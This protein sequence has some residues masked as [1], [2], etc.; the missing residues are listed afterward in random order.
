MCIIRHW[1]DI[2]YSWA[3][4]TTWLIVSWYVVTNVNDFIRF[5]VHGF[6]LTLLRQV[7]KLTSSSNYATICLELYRTLQD[8]NFIRNIIAN[9]LSW[10]INSL[11]LLIYSNGNHWSCPHSPRVTIIL[12]LFFTNDINNDV[13]ILEEHAQHIIL[14]CPRYSKVL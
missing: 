2:I 4:L 14:C 11:K 1:I 5:S 13:I 3:Y 6:F 10:L 9:N 7:L 8:Y 12:F